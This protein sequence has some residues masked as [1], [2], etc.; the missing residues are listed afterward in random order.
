M[1]HHNLAQNSSPPCLSSTSSNWSL[2][3]HFSNPLFPKHTTHTPITTINGAFIV[4][5]SPYLIFKPVYTLTHLTLHKLYRPCPNQHFLSVYNIPPAHRHATLL[6]DQHLQFLSNNI[7]TPDT[8]E[9]VTT[10]TP[11]QVPGFSAYTSQVYSKTHPPN[12]ERTSTP[13]SQLFC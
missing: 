4:S 8:H 5:F 11:V 13:S 3:W 12:H 9:H 10:T 6:P 1:S 2:L 7:H